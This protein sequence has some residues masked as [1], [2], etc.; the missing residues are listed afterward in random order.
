M[1]SKEMKDLNKRLYMK[2]VEKKHIAPPQTNTGERIL[3]RISKRNEFTN[4]LF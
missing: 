2:F 4:V 3:E 1:S